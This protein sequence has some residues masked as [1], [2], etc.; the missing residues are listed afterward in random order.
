AGNGPGIRRLLGKDRRMLYIVA[1]SSGFRCSELAS[2]TPES[3]DLASD[4]PCVVVEAA[5]SKRRR[6]DTQPLPRELAPV[7]LAWLQNK[8][9]R[10]VLWPGG[11]INHAAKMVRSDLAAARAVWIRSATTP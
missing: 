7:L 11:W 10:Q 6:R 5:Y 8:P 3:F 9:A 4:S 1:A 2:L